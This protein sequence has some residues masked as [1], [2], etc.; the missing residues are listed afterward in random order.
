MTPTTK[1]KLQSLI[2]GL[3]MKDCHIVF[4]MLEDRRRE[5]QS[6]K[7]LSFSVGDLVEW[8]S[9]KRGTKVQGRILKVN[10]ITIII[11]ENNSPTQ[12]KVSP[13]FL[14]LVKEKKSA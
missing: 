5:I 10:R 4:N 13:S 14:S 12:W 8:T 6:E 3:D 1:N 9:R 11:Q 2:H 7:K